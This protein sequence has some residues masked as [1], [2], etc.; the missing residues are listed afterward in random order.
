[1]S[2]S[3][4]RLPDNHELVEGAGKVKTPE[5]RMWGKGIIG[6]IRQTVLTWWVKE[7]T[8]FNQKTIAVTLLIFIT[9]ISPTLAFG[10]TYGG[11]TNNLIGPIETMLATSWVGCAHSLIGGMP[12]TIIGST[13]PVLAFTTALTNIANSMDVP[14]QTLY[15]WTSVWLV[16]YCFLAAFFDVTRYIQYATRFTDEIFALL[17]VSIFILDAV[18][19]PFS[20]SGLLRYLD[21]NHPFH[22]SN[23]EDPNY[24]YYATAFLSIIIGFGT[25]SLIFFFR[26]FKFSSFF[27]ADGIRT[28]IHDFAVITSVIIFTLIKEFGFPE[29]E[30]QTLNVPDQFEPTFQC[31]DASCNTS[32]PLECPDQESPVGVRTWFADFGDLNGKGWVPIVAAGPAIG[33]F[34]LV[35]LDNGIT[36]HLIQHKSHKLTH[37]EAYNWDL[38]L[39]GCFNLINGLLGLPWLVASTVPCIIHLKSLAETDRDGNIISVQETRLT[40]L[41]A[42]LLLGLSILFLGVLK[43]IPLPCLYGVFLFMGL[44]SMPAIQFWNR[45]LLFFMQPSK[46]PSTSYT[47]YM[48]KSHIH[49]YTIFQIFFFGLVF[50]VQNWKAIAIAFPFMTLLCI[51]A[52]LFLAPK[53][54]EGWELVLL[55]GED[56]AIEEWIDA[57]ED[58]I[59][60]YEAAKAGGTD[61]KSL[62]G[63]T[64][65]GSDGEDAELDV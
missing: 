55:D 22:A 62:G 47:D 65:G 48:T 59:R 39:S 61:S 45:I 32:F 11:V 12:L 30:T 4:P 40:N 49:K 44:S 26:S 41:F 51:P 57:K 37:G 17:I 2:S 35:Y 21:P 14:F 7:M 52:R 29:I 1:M 27:C 34:V 56:E 18:G 16:G 43:L 9:I 42:H 25:T 23:S 31:C 5:A 54:L 6:D 60:Q 63:G 13:G 50:G 15:A 38:L 64:E 8:N 20:N 53:F 33:A 10:A 46:Y 24:S 58:S 36:W 19:D 3:E 28:S